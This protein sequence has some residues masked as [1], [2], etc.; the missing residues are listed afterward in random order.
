MT[1]DCN[2]TGF[3]MAHQSSHQPD[4]IDADRPKPVA[5]SAT[6]ARIRLWALVAVAAQAI[7]VISWLVAA[8]W[9]GPRYSILAHSISDMYAVAAPDAAFLVIAFT[10]CGAATILFAVLSAWPSL[11][12]G[13]WTA[14]VGSILLALSIL[15]LGDLLT[16]AE[17]LACRMA[18]PGCTAAA[19]IAN[20]GGRLDSIL[21]T[22][23]IALFVAA[24]FF[25]AAA[26]KRTPGWHA[27]IW[28]ARSLMIL[29]LAFFLADGLLG[30]TTGL[31]GLFER[32]L[33]ATAAAAIALL[34]AAVLR[35]SPR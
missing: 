27:W 21:S 11:R 25:L 15:G 6:K 12:P 19:Q 34:G 7:F 3:V 13:G 23:G 10:L 4:A 16:P 24:G 29:A 1:S 33:A 22:I 2:R 28:P 8:L 35:R 31:G 32:L 14:T 20:M 30:R 18:D 26:M 17:R 5:A 9:Q